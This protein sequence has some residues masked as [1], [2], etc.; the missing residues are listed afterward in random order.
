MEAALHSQH[1]THPD[2]YLDPIAL[3]ALIVAAAELAWTIYHDLKP[4]T[5]H[6]APHVITRQIRIELADHTPIEPTQRDRIID[7]VVDETILNHD[8]S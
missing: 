2:Q 3:A 4:T 7:V 6:P 1:T 5:P 8:E